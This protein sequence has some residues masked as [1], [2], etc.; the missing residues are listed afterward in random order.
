MRRF[1]QIDTRTHTNAHAY[2]HAHKWQDAQN[3]Q[4][5]ENHKMFARENGKERHR[6]NS[7]QMYIS[8]AT[9]RETKAHCEMVTIETRTRNGMM[10]M[11]ING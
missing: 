4:S 9:D 2:A 1:R 10:T 11:I 5:I 8:N 3:Y 6:V 7:S